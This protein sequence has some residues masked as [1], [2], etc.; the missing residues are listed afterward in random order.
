MLSPAGE[1]NVSFFDEVVNGQVSNYRYSR[2]MFGDALMWADRLIKVMILP[3]QETPGP[4]EYFF[5]Q[6]QIVNSFIVS[7]IDVMKC[8]VLYGFGVA[9]IGIENF[10]QMAIIEVNLPEH[11]KI[12]QAYN[13]TPVTD[14]NWRRV[15][16]DFNMVFREKRGSHD[17]SKIIS[18]EDKEELIRRWKTS[19]KTGNH[20]DF[21]Q[22]ILSSSFLVT[23]AKVELKTG[24]FDI[25][26]SDKNH[27][28]K[29]MIWI[30]DTFFI[31]TQ[32]SAK[33]LEARGFRLKSESKLIQVERDKWV[34]F[35]EAMLK[36]G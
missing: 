16:N 34:S 26:E 4:V 31:I 10:I 3:R 21:I 9:R 7:L 23:D 32:Y 29:C 24:V 15:K 33:I 13:Y 8:H 20:P 5:L 35:K 18:D 28:G 30:I 2:K 14:G 12:W 27:I 25:D 22:T 17:Y 36:K 6:D 1:I 19:S 11:L